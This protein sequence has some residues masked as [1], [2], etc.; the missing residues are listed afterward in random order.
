VLD[1]VYREYAPVVERYVRGLTSRSR[2]KELAQ[3]A[4]IAD[5][6]QEVFARAFAPAARQSYDG[7]RDFGAYLVAIAHN[8]FVDVARTCHRESPRTSDELRDLL[9]RS[10]VQD[11][12]MFTKAPLSFV[13]TD[14]LEGLSV[15]LN[16]IYRHRFVQGAS[17][18]QVAKVLGISRRRVRT[19]EAHLREGLRRV[20]L[21]AG[22]PASI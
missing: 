21:R 12:D 9:E 11:G 6:V 15:E 19:Q 22:R 8:C 2:N 16:A 7:A 17:Q 3:A 14:Y 4:S 20:V 10:A 5:L 13:L 18:A 1:G